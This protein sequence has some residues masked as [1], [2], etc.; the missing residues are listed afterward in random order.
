MKEFAER[1]YTD[2]VTLYDHPDK[3]AEGCVEIN[4]YCKFFGEKTILFRTQNHH[5]KITNS[6]TMTF[7]TFVDT[8]KRDKEVFWKYTTENIPKDF[9]LFI[10]LGKEDK[11]LSSPVPSLSTHCNKGY[12]AP[13]IDWEKCAIN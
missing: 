5:W 12:T 8:L 11:L 10:E 1:N 13:F 3:Y 6:T 4:P 9:L 2:Y 7:G